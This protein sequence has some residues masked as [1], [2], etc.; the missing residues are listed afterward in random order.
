[1][2]FAHHTVFGLSLRSNVLIPGLKETAPLSAAPDVDVH[3]GCEPRFDSA[4]VSASRDL[5]FAS[6]V[7]AESGEPSLQVWRVLPESRIE[8]GYYD[9]L[10]F[11]VDQHGR[12]IWAKWPDTLSIDDVAAYLIGPVFG[13]VLQLRGITCL[14]ASA[15]AFGDH[16]VVFAG[17]DGA[18]KSTTAAA[19]ARRGHAVISDDVVALVEREGAFYVVPAYPHLSL[20][21]DAVDLLYG[22]G[23]ELPDLSRSLVKRRL[24]LDGNNLKFAE[25]PL[26]L[27][28]IFVLG[29]RSASDAAPYLED[30][31]PQEA[32]MSL[33]G[34]SFAGHLL[35]KK[36]RAAEFA[37]LA[38]V[39]TTVPV[40]RLRSHTDPMQIQILCD[41][42]VQSHISSRVIH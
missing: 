2:N 26:P 9:G 13:L 31:P 22:P 27:A 36:A 17:G 21:Q 18:G 3:F 19:F 28:A 14:H 41:V 4:S 30:L 34:S 12:N 37:S 11:W 35:D 7:K 5:I 40:K 1:V 32:L 8:L 10:R 15:V 42:I 39:V 6:S 20:W 23:K 33:V 16:A 24:E 25:K 29:E 38:Q